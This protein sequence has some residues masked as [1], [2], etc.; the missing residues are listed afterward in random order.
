TGCRDPAM[1]AN[2]PILPAAPA[3]D[4]AVVG[5]HALDQ[6]RGN[7]PV[8]RT[9]PSSSRSAVVNFPTWM[10][11]AP[12]SWGQRRKRLT[13]GGVTVTAVAR[14]ERVVWTMGDGTTVTCTGPGTPYAAGVSD[15]PPPPTAAPSTAAPR[16]GSPAS[17]SA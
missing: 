2:I 16:P 14:P 15:P 10:W 5:Q 17:A 12:E 8:I 4:P 6:L 1:N 9:S 13:E 11:V 7:P 3:A